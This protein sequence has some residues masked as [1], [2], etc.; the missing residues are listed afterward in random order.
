M[1]VFAFPDRICRDRGELRRW[2][3]QKRLDPRG[4]KLHR[5]PYPRAQLKRLG[6]Q[7]RSNNLPGYTQGGS[8]GVP[9]LAD[10]AVKYH[11]EAKTLGV[12]V[13]ELYT[14]LVSDAQVNPPEWNTQGIIVCSSP[15]GMQFI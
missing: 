13:E 2:L 6:L 10:F 14:A 1:D 12:D 9:I 3:A 5:V 7:C 15:L 4:W 8:N 11:N